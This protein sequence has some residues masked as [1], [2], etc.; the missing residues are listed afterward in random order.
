MGKELNNL[1]REIWNNIN[2]I[3]WYLLIQAKKKN[4]KQKFQSE[5]TH[6]K[7]LSNLTHNKVLPFPPDYVITNLS[8]YKISQEEANIQS[9]DLETESH[10]K[11]L[12]GQMFLLTL[13]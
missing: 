9:M 7:K 13:I 8:L 3:E 4:V 1:K 6:E 10:Q 5:K 11:D 12:T 2:G